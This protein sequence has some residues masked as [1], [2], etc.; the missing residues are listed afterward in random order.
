MQSSQ[1]CAER[2]SGTAATPSTNIPGDEGGSNS[3]GRPDVSRFHHDQLDN[4]IV[5]VS[6]RKR[7]ALIPPRHAP[8]L[9]TVGAIGRMSERS[10]A[11]TNDMMGSD[12]DSHGV[13]FSLIQ[14]I[15]PFL[16][17]SKESDGRSG[18]NGRV[19]SEAIAAAR[20][21]A[22]RWFPRLLKLVDSESLAGYADSARGGESR[23]RSGN[24]SSSDS[25]DSGGSSGGSS[26]SS[27]S[28]WSVVHEL[29]PGEALYIPTGWFHQV[30]SMGVHMAVNIWWKSRWL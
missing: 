14:D 12:G 26:S 1:K 30:Q 6:G 20:T 18:S 28:S 25:G 15:F 8:D 11:Y 23:R 17:Q 29:G 9:Y 13:H 19:S 7:Y 3:G 16:P 5:L 27:G 24:G 21:M 10:F 22:R 4:L 2:R